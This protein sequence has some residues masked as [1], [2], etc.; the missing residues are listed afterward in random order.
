M[1]LNNNF[2][3]FSRPYFLQTLNILVHPVK[4]HLLFKKAE[5]LSNVLC[6]DPIFC[7]GKSISY[8]SFD[9]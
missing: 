3:G 5:G 6:F 4:K 8:L 9:A 2:K 1:R 7:L